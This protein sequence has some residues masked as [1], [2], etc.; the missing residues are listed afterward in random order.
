MRPNR[1]ATSCADCGARVAAGAGR[2]DG[3]PWRVSCAACAVSSVGEQIVD[4]ALGERGHA[5]RPYQ[6]EAVRW[7]QSRP[8]ALLADDQGLGKTV[9]VLAAL[10]EGAKALVVAPAVARGVWLDH[11]RDMRPD[12]S[13]V[14]LAGRDAWHEWRSGDVAVISWACLPRDLTKHSTAELR[15]ALGDLPDVV[16]FD[17]IHYAKSGRTQRSRRARALALATE[18]VWGLS[19]TPLKNRP[20]DLHNVL[21][22]LRLDGETWPTWRSFCDDWGAR[23]GRWGTTWDGARAPRVVEVLQ[24]VMLRRRKAD[25][26]RE[27]PA[28]LHD[29]ITVGIDSATRRAC[30]AAA[31][32]LAEG[33][34]SLDELTQEAL[35]ARQG[36][37]FERLATACRALATAKLP[38]LLDLLDLWE[39]D[40][41]EPRL[42]WSRHVAPLQ[43]LGKRDGWATITGATSQNRREDLVA[44][45]QRGELK[46]L[47]L[48]IGAAGTAITL[49]AGSHS[50]YL[51]RAWTPGD[52]AQS[53]DRTHRLGQDRACRYTLLVAEHELDRALARLLHDK[54]ATITSTIDAA[55]R[56]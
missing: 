54:A 12:L 26:L 23:A 16:I 22:V 11:V 7:L 46:G 10:P 35:S 50:I 37:S 13:A 41:D 40:S 6:R 3:P 43:A 15:E 48:S 47:A 19:G 51:D 56:I 31:R 42:V 17:E 5:L 28:K 39:L 33:G 25:V 9:E 44:S 24:R 29:Q 45:F 14:Y 8:H 36:A 21:R 27:L 18:R 52:N 2:L 34:V 30:N 32:A 38:A 53:E 4:A 20:P 1:Y 49:T 55:S